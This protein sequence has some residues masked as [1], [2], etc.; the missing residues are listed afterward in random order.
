MKVSIKQISQITGFSPATVSNALNRKR[1]VNRGTSETIFKVAESLG[2]QSDK[3]VTKIRFVTYRK[4]GQIIDDS[5]IFPEMIGGVERQAK[6]LGYETTFSRLDREDESFDERLE[7][8][9]ADTSSLMILLGTEMMEEDY[10]PF[11]DYK[12]HI[13]ILDGWSEEM[14]FDAV[15]IN[16]TDAACHAMEYLIEKGHTKIGY[17]KGDYRI[18]AFRYRE[19]GYERVHERHGL[20]VRPEYVI[21]LGTQLETA[22]EGMKKYL[23]ENPELPTA[24]FADDDV[25]ALGAMR[26]LQEKG[27][28]IPEDVSIIGFDDTKYGA[29]SRPGLTTIHVHKQ[30]MGEVAVR[31]ALDNIKYPGREGKM[32]IQVCT[33]FIERGSVKNL[34]IE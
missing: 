12:G 26:A 8:V 27:I 33:T 3:T 5:Q 10:I 13:I 16:N 31:R 6:E 32:K 18:K 29:V 2:Y 20:T 9:L 22:Y 23:G 4:N 30:E 1:G 25:I 19:Y 34:S 14:D 21:T 28:R 11:R 15:L 7:E 24:Y 17:L